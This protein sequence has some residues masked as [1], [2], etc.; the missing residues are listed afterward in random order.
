PEN[1]RT[2]AMCYLFDVLPT[3]GK[4]CGVAGPRTSD[5][6]EFTAVL[7]DPARPARSE[8][9]F[10]FRDVQ[11]SVRTDR[12]K[13]IRYP[14]VDRT[15]LFDLQADPQ[16]TTNLADMPEQKERVIELTKLLEKQQE[17]YGDSAPL[18]VAKPKPAEFTPPREGK[19]PV[20]PKDKK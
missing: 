11:R 9:M 18:R 5:G 1:K 2:Q 8:L 12:W 20:E 10:A 7:K 15:Q 3:L 14:Q 16:E 4:R 19:P 17:Q 13:L 6:V